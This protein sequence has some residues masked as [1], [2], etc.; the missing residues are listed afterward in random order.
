MGE[1]DRHRRRQRGQIPVGT[2]LQRFKGAEV[3]LATFTGWLSGVGAE[4][5]GAPH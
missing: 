3:A 4:P 5:E 2:D 1:P